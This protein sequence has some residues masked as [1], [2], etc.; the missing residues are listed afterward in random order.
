[1]SCSDNDVYLGSMVCTAT[2]RVEPGQYSVVVSAQA[3][4]ANG[5][6][7]QATKQVYWYGIL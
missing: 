7:M 1:M 6:R 4:S 5:P 3:W 2:V